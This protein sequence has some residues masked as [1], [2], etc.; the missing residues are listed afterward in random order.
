MAENHRFFE[1]VEDIDGKEL[2]AKLSQLNQ[3]ESEDQQMQE[4]TQRLK[5][6]KESIDQEKTTAEELAACAEESYEMLKTKISELK[7]IVLKREQKREATERVE[8]ETAKHQVS[9]TEAKANRHRLHEE[10]AAVKDKLNKREE[11]KQRSQTITA[12]RAAV[13]KEKIKENTE[14][15]NYIKTLSGLRELPVEDPDS[16]RLEFIPE[17]EED[18]SLN[19]TMHFAVDLSGRV[20]LTGAECGFGGGGNDPKINFLS[21][22][23]REILVERKGALLPLD[24]LKGTVSKL[25]NDIPAK[26]EVITHRK[27]TPP[28]Q[29][30]LSL[31]FPREDEIQNVL[32]LKVDV[33]FINAAP[34]GL[35]FGMAFKMASQLGYLIPSWTLVLCFSW[36]G[37]LFAPVINTC[38]ASMRS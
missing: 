24:H 2:R 36:R 14:L 17:G 31:G 4:V 3:I 34:H 26:K 20:H 19:L 15:L 11:S 5:N 9:L 32:V 25:T 10:L 30:I 18:A 12:K 1:D 23:L 29:L 37:N 27:L 8:S 22:N 7:E 33:E 16:I 38:L 28:R 6:C 13:L 35:K 21:V